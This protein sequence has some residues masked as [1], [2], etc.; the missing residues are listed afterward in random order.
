MYHLLRTALVGSRGRLF[1]RVLVFLC[2]T[3][4]C[5][6][7]LLCFVSCARVSI[8]VGISLVVCGFRIPL[9]SS[10]RIRIRLRIS[11]LTSHVF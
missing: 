2:C 5:V 6:S 11:S 7:G 1:L 10:I 8:R 3:R 4:L 9:R